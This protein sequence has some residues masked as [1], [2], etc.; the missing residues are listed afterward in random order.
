MGTERYYIPGSWYIVDDRTGFPERSFRCRKEWTN[1]LVNRNRWEPRQPQDFV[2]GVVDDQTVP[3][4]RP[5]PV[6]ILVGPLQTTLTAALTPGN[7][8]IT[9]ASSSRFLNNDVVEIMLDNNE[10]FRTTIF[11][12]LSLTQ[13]V[14]PSPGLPYKA[15][16]GNIVTDLTAQAAITI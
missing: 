15:A 7:T 14:I 2:K 3:E 16:S 4:T 6:D 9:V 11:S 10:Y 5:R 1:A 13:F 12:V 8:T